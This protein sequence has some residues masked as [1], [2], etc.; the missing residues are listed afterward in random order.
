V[1]LAPAAVSLTLNVFTCREALSVKQC[2]HVR[3]TG[4]PWASD[5]VG[6]QAAPDLG[7]IRSAHVG[8]LLCMRATVLR[9]TAV[10]MLE[11]QRT[12][13]CKKCKHRCASAVIQC[14]HITNHH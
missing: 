13:A 2:V 7:S 10:Q 5:S 3:I 14:T 4:L 9:A 12:Y 11:R 6:R 1:N 8:R